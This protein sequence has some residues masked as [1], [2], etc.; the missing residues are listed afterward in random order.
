MKRGREIGVRKVLG[1]T[2]V[3]LMAQFLG[4]SVF[5]SLIALMVGLFLVK[6]AFTF[7]SIDDLLGKKEL[8]NFYTEPAL[9]LWML[10]LS[11][12]VGLLSGIYPALYHSSILPIF[13]LTGKSH[14]GKKG[15]RVRQLLVL[16]QFVIS[17]GG[18]AA[19]ILM[20]I[21]MHFV[22]NIDLG[23]TKENRVVTNLIG[24]D[25]IEKV[26]ILKTKLLS[27]SRILEVTHT[28]QLPGEEIREYSL[29]IES[30]ERTMKSGVLLH[31]MQVGEDF[32]KVIGAKIKLGRDFSKRSSTDVG[33]SYLVN[34][35]MVK[36]MGW[37]E[38]LGK[39]IKAGSNSFY[40]GRVVG[41]VKD[42]NFRSLHRQVQ[43]LLINLIQ[44]NFSTLSPV[45][46]KLIRRKIV[47]NIS[48]REVAETLNYIKD[49]FEEFDAKHPF[50]YEFLSDIIDQHYL[51]DKRLMDLIA[52]FSGISIFISCLG[53]FGLAAFTT[54]Q[55]TKEIG[56]RKVLGASTFQI[57][58]ILSRSILLIVL[59]ASVIAS[60]EAYLVVDEW[61]TR[62]AYHAGINPLV[63]LFSAVFAMVVAFGTVALQAFKTAQANPVEALRYE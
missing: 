34:E 36:M 5:F 48:G 43:P 19:T 15:L 49:V 56:I 11:L 46:R 53:V 18:I 22:D 24:A 30:N 17:I 61:L 57:I 35:A 6:A 28:I 8:M 45:L 32:I 40:D 26:P 7:T 13:A 42:F 25:Q 31:F 41:V 44:D 38:P 29:M 58:V 62:F 63:F 2:R 50:E 23:F 4:E 16:I 37:V 54:E 51:S 10:G 3:Q 12:I 1:A 39:R 27:E 55:R 14:V 9:L 52:I 33:R 20:A 59:V 60:V 47:I 21:Q